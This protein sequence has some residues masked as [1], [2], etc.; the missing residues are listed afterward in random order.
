MSSR[1][2]LSL[3]IA[4]FLLA[5]ITVNHTNLSSQ[6]SRRVEVVPLEDGLG[7][8]SFAFDHTSGG[9]PYTGLSDGRIVK[10]QENERRWLNFAVTS[11]RR[12]GC[13]GAHDHVSKEHICGRPLGLRFDKK[14]GDLYIADAYMGLLK[15][16]PE[17]GFAISIATEAQGIPFRFCNSLDIDQSTGVVYFTDSSSLHQRRNYMSVILSGDRTGR[18]MK[19]D[20]DSQ[21]V[22]VLLQNLSFPNGV[23]LSRDGN[24]ILLAE[25]TKC[26]I[27][28]YWLK[29]SKAGS[30]EVIAQ[31]PGFP[32]NVKLSPRG[33]FWVGI[34]SRR[35]K[36]SEWALSYPWIGNA[37]LKLPIDIIKVHSILVKLRGDGGMAVRLSE[38]GE[39]LEILHG[40]SIK[41][42]H[43]ISEVEERDG[44]LWIGS[45][46]MPFAGMYKT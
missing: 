17:G 9:G 7:P 35:Q 12:D 14:S 39:L 16:G 5:L 2:I 20:P 8:E 18:L 28:K 15:V 3:T 6:K 24:Y 37:L 10:W 44:T 33:G 13:E 43:S 46:N 32:D 38:E 29:T 45:I 1:L 36:I 25:T 30:F 23:V 42:W 31:L 26:R 40:K 11:L 27:L 19:Y 22:T 34:Y 4:V 21:K 41:R